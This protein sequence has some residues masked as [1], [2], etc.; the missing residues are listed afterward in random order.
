MK[1]MMASIA[2]FEENEDHSVIQFLIAGFIGVLRGWLDNMLNENVIQ[3]SANE[4]GE[5]NLVHKLIYAIT[6]HFCDA[7][8]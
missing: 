4:K 5:Q 6:M 2:Y 1:S 3:T 8:T 7:S